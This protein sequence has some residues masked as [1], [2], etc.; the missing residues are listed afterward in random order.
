MIFSIIILAA[1]GTI[2]YYHYAQGF[3]SATISCSR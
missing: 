3:F 2:A 1:V